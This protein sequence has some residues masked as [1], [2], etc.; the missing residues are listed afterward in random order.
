MKKISLT[1]FFLAF[2]FANTH[3]TGQPAKQP[4]ITLRLLEAEL[5]DV[6]RLLAESGKKNI[7]VDG[8]IKKN[9]T[10]DL[11]EVD[12]E[13]ALRMILEDQG[14]SY[15]KEDN[16][17]RVVPIETVP[18]S[19]RLKKQIFNLEFASSTSIAPLIKSFLSS[20]GSVIQ[21]D[22]HN[23]FIVID[24]EENI[25]QVSSFLLKVDTPIPQ[26]A[27][28]A[29][30]IETTMSEK[31]KSLITWDLIKNY[32]GSLEQRRSLGFMGVDD[33]EKSPGSLYG[34]IDTP[35]LELIME[36]LKQDSRV[37]FVSCPNVTTLN[38]EKA[39]I[40]VTTSKV[41]GK[42]T[43][44]Q[45]D[46]KIQRSTSVSQQVGIKLEVTPCITKN[47]LITLK[48]VP[49][50]SSANASEL[51]PSEAMDV[52]ESKATTTIVIR[53]GETLVIGGLIKSD[54]MAVT[55]KIPF[56]S[57]IPVLGKRLFTQRG[58]EQV[59]K[60]MTIFITARILRQKEQKIEITK[61]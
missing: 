39:A 24:R 9:I 6:I 23:S 15:L 46:E 4:L 61:K 37:R 44:Y 59:N 20:E 51:F 38:N 40:E 52:T 56:F 3:F 5:V 2:I 18:S 8:S 7:I 35:R 12:F 27:I 13:N 21:D 16:I 48:V 36:R 33:E 53:S 47:D 42:E 60:E 22:P 14:Y 31:D 25:I 17:F 43:S 45:L 28:E 54:E 19:N 34:V 49:S 41:V 1:F 26:V 32:T 29:R 11:R 30:I 58:R 57:D 55:R 50:I 10:V